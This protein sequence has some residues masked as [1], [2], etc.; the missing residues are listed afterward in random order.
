VA[1]PPVGIKVHNRES[2]IDGE[3]KQEEDAELPPGWSARFGGRLGVQQ[4]R[5]PGEKCE[6]GEI[7]DGELT[8]DKLADA[9]GSGENEKQQMTMS[10]VEI[11]VGEYLADRSLLGPA[12]LQLRDVGPVQKDEQSERGGLSRHPGRDHPPRKTVAGQ[13][14]QAIAAERAGE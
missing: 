6:S 9:E 3:G 4:D 8:E 12:A 1:R 7:A 14:E 11:G 5:N 2:A 10:P 13:A